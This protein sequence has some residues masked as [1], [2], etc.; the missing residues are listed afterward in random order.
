MFKF[1]SRVQKAYSCVERFLDSFFFSYGFFTA[2]VGQT[3]IFTLNEY[4]IG[5]AFLLKIF[6]VE[7]LE[8]EI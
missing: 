6:D 4:A 8:V 2:S 3:I 7:N 1:N 5:R